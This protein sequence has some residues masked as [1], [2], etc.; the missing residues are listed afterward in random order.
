MKKTTKHAPKKDGR[1]KPN[2]VQLR[3]LVVHTSRPFLGATAPG[4]AHVYIMVCVS[5]ARVF[6]ARHD[7]VERILNNT[8]GLACHRRIK[9]VFVSDTY[10]RFI[11]KLLLFIKLFFFFPS[12]GYYIDRDDDVRIPRG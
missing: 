12:L 11:K 8:I 9:I 5:G 2:K 7:C 6:R 1:I 4:G 3:G 10:K